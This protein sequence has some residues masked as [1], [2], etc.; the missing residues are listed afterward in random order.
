VPIGSEIAVSP[1]PTD[2][3]SLIDDQ[4]ALRRLHE[5]AASALTSTY[6]VFRV[7]SWEEV[8]IGAAVRKSR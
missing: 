8:I 1:R 5:A 7:L 6:H 4:F 3:E 2:Y